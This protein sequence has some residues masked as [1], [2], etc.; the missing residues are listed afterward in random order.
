MIYRF[1]AGIW[2]NHAPAW[3]EFTACAD[4]FRRKFID[5]L[6]ELRKIDGGASVYLQ[7][8]C[9]CVGGGRFYGLT[10]PNTQNSIA[11]MPEW[12]PESY[13]VKTIFST[14]R[15]TFEQISAVAKFSLNLIDESTQV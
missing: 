8:L 6:I 11:L 14:L 1:R 9:P 5:E 2:H 7:V 3:R 12:T 15:N 4:N 10:N 13:D